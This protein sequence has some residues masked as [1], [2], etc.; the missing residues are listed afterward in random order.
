MIITGLILFLLPIFLFQNCMLSLNFL[1]FYQSFP[2]LFYLFYFFLY[3]SCC[4]IIKFIHCDISASIKN[5]LQMSNFI[6]NIDTSESQIVQT[7]IEL[8][9]ELERRDFKRNNNS[10][11]NTSSLKPQ[12]LVQILRKLQLSRIYVRESQGNSTNSHNN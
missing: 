5:L 4:Y 8:S 3:H 9:Q 1:I 11:M 6:P 7:G 10:S 12:A 2:I